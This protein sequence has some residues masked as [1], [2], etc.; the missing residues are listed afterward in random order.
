[1]KHAVSFQLNLYN[2]LEELKTAACALCAA[3]FEF[4]MSWSRVKDNER[5]VVHH[6]LFVKL[7]EIGWDGG[8]TPI[9][10]GF[11]FVEFLNDLWHGTTACFSP[12]TLGFNLVSSWQML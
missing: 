5:M 8:S 4:K 1:M 9:L 6:K 2:D 11:H 12:S 3:S 10:D 7:R